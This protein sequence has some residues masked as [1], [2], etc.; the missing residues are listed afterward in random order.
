MVLFPLGQG[1]APSP[2]A[3]PLP[4]YLLAT[5]VPGGFAL[6]VGALAAAALAM[7][8]SLLMRPPLTARAAADRLSLGLGL[9]MCLAPATRFGYLVYPL[10][11]VGWF[12]LTG[13]A[14]PPREG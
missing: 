7:A 11:L 14:R 6:A 9:A 8:A 3:S 5:Y 10:V 2:A 12:R 13:P 1:G 4:G